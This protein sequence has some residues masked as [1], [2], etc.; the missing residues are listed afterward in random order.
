MLS[1][2]IQ[3]QRSAVI[4]R[5]FRCVGEATPL[6]RPPSTPRKLIT[7]S[8]FIFRRNSPAVTGAHKPCLF[9]TYDRRHYR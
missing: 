3:N 6:A 8:R 4:A 5:D 9:N 2:E 7:R 1:D